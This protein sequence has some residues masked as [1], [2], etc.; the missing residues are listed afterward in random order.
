MRLAVWI[1]PYVLSSR[2][3]IGRRAKY[4]SARSPTWQSASMLA[5]TIVP[6]MTT[7]SAYCLTL[8]SSH[9]RCARHS[10]ISGGLTF[11]AGWNVKLDCQS[12]SVPWKRISNQI[13]SASGSAGILMTNAPVAAVFWYVACAVLQ[14]NAMIGPEKAAMV[15][16]LLGAR[17]GSPCAFTVDTKTICPGSIDGCHDPLSSANGTFLVPIITIHLGARGDV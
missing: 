12:R 9:S 8:S 7:S 17:F 5:T 14:P 11:C 6:K 4:W 2:K 13:R 15:I 10:V 16:Q 1:E 3:K